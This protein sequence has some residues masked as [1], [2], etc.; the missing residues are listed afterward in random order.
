M[1][2]AAV[3]PKK[4][5]IK[6]RCPKIRYKGGSPQCTCIEPCSDDKYG[7]NVHLILKNNPRL[8]IIFLVTLKNGRW[9]FM[10]NF[11]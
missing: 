1:K 5:Q 2:Q 3:K 8:L 10:Q 6:Y 7:K 4:G 11:C 9:N